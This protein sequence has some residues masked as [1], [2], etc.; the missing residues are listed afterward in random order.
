[1][2][3][4]PFRA[5]L[6]YTQAMSDR[7]A[8][9]ARGP[10]AK[11]VERRKAIL[12]TTLEVFSQAGYRGATLRAIARQL[13]VSPTL[14]QHYFRTREDLLAEVVREW[15]NENLRRSDGRPQLAHWLLAIRNNQRVPGLIRVYTAFAVEATDP[16]HP[17]RAFFKERYG[18][19]TARIVADIRD[20][21]DRKLVPADIDPERTA[22]ILIAACEGLQ[23][24]WLHEPTFDLYEEFC[25]LL[26][27]FSLTWPDAASRHLERSA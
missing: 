22:R 6:T 17:A 21:Q 19:I 16:D 1:M 5:D 12:Q 9:Y 20:Q 10:Y 27:Q 15:D 18:E 3:E 23:I 14:L 2:S 13:D 26:R 4:D 11:G 24:R 25:F 8:A 7:S